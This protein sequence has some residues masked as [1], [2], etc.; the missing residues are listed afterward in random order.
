[1]AVQ[2][3]IH[4]MKRTGGSL[5]EPVEVQ[6]MPPMVFA[7]TFS[8]HAAD[9]VDLESLPCVCPDDLREFW[10][11]AETARLFEDS[12]YGQWGLEIL[13]PKQ[14]AEFTHWLRAER[15]KDF[16]AGDLVVG[17]FLGDSE[18]LIVRCDPQ[19]DD[20]G[21]VQIGLPLD[22]RMDWEQAGETFGNFLENYAEA[23]G[24]KFWE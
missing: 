18:I 23:R 3:T 16:I 9:V 8:Q 21:R 17:R 13:A 24:D 2:D 14:A 11:E 12:E 5:A 4:L 6:G 10:S 15:R 19:V 7:C 1:M 20:Y 22:P